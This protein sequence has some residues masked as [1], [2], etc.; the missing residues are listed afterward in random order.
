MESPSLPAPPNCPHGH[1]NL[2]ACILHVFYCALS[3]LFLCHAMLLPDRMY[4]IYIDRYI[5]HIYYIYI[6]VLYT[7]VN[8]YIICVY[9]IYICICMQKGTHCTSPASTCQEQFHKNIPKWKQHQRNTLESKPSSDL[10]ENRRVQYY[11]NIKTSSIWQ[12]KQVWLILSHGSKSRAFKLT[13][14]KSSLAIL[15]CTLRKWLCI[16]KDL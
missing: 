4:F 10:V 1:P 3:A 7:H 5:I 6:Y 13:T 11:N 12:K 15:I 2:R 16:D 9:I 14:Q 8:A